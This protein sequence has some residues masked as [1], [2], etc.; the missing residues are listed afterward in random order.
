LRCRVAHYDDR[1]FLP[2]QVYDTATGRLCGHPAARQDAVRQEVRG[3]LRRIVRRIR[4]H[5]PTTNITIRGESH[6]GRREV[7]DWCEDNGLDYVFGL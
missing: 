5:W 7:M 2:I 3:H 6:C 4:T 1:C